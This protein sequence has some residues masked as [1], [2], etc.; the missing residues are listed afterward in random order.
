MKK[1][2]RFFFELAKFSVRLAGHILRMVV[3]SA[4]ASIMII[5]AI[6]V[7]FSR[8]TIFKGR[9]TPGPVVEHGG[10]KSLSA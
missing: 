5:C 6:A 7:I 2:L 8:K 3:V 9:A 4:Y 1:A 10:E